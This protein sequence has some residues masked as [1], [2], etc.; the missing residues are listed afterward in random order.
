[1][2]T[3]LTSGVLGFLMF[4]LNYAADSDVVGKEL[5]ALEGKWKLVRIVKGGQEV[6]L[7]ASQV[8]TAWLRADGTVTARI[9]AGKIAATVAPNPTGDPKTIE[10]RH[11]TGRYQ[12]RR[13]YAFYKLQGDR[14]TVIAVKPG[15]PKEAL[16]G[17][18][19]DT[20]SNA[21]LLVF[22]RTKDRK[23]P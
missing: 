6:P 18:F 14:L 3:Q 12:G 7:G 9:P 15:A 23:N 21:L 10:I 2:M 5:L 20:Q 16:Q 1:M 8:I 22:E 13:Q 11:E 19:A 4:P 17:D